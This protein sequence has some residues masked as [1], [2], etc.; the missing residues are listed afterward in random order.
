MEGSEIFADS[1]KVTVVKMVKFTAQVGLLLN[2]ML[3]NACV[4]EFPQL[5]T[6]LLH[7]LQLIEIREL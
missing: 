4:L 7:F 6:G 2:L 5:T 1:E 3:H